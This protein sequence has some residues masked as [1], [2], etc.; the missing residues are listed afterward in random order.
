MQGIAQLHM[1]RIAHCDIKMDNLLSPMICKHSL[2]VLILIIDLV[3]LCDYGTARK[4]NFK[5]Y[6]GSR[7]VVTY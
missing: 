1:L 2:Q 7:K 4:L 6:P 5:A 3:K